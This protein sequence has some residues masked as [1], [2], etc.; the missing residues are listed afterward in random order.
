MP[1]F[2]EF[3]TAKRSQQD[4]L[5]DAALFSGSRYGEPFTTTRIEWENFKAALESANEEQIHRALFESPYLI[6]YVIDT[7]GHHGT[8]VFSKQ[9]IKTQSSDQVPGLIPDFLVVAR[10]SLGY[11]WHIIELKKPNVQ[12]ANAKGDG[13][14]PTGHKA[15]AQCATY[16]AH[17]R[18]YIETV[19]SNIGVRELIQPKSVVLVIGDAETETDRQRICRSNFHGMTELVRVATYDRIVR[20]VRNDHPQWFELQESDRQP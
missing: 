6:Q 2:F 12:F 18:D 20:G 19:R 3:A 5:D 13:Y 17:F 9:M 10:N 1:R 11:S 14:S 15:I 8:W 7:S 4:R 16:Y